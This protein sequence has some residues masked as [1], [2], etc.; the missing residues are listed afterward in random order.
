MEKNQ[1]VRR[2]T[3][4]ELLTEGGEVRVK[5]MSQKLNTSVVTIRKDLDELQKE[6]LLERV[7]G[8][9]VKNCNAQQDLFFMDR[10][11]I[12]KEEKKQIANMAA[13]LINERDSVIINNGSTS[14]YV[15]Q[16]LKSKKNVIVITNSL[17]ILD[18]LSC[19][20]NIATLFLG[21][22][23]DPKMQITHGE[24]TIAQLSKYK[25]DKLIIGMDGIDIKAGATTYNH[26][27]CAIM[28]LMIEHSQRKILVV[29]D[30]KFRKIT[31]AHVAPL[32]DFNTIITNYI[33]ENEQ[34]YEDLR[35]LGLEVITD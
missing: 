33:P 8:G 23:L 22:F 21:G 15:A 9:A 17:M 4:M 24:D 1:V 13:N 31:F 2:Q 5:E 30:S 29:D 18:E 11:D 3:I 10:K 35:M 6:G 25:A 19:Y 26:V 12:K 28:R 20:K 14:Y 27:D 32:T 34:Y 16:E 7:H